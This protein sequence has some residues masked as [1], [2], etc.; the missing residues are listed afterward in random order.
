MRSGSQQFSSRANYNV[1]LRLSQPIHG[2]TYNKKPME[3]ISHFPNVIST[4]CWC[5]NEF[6]Q[7]IMRD[8]RRR[9]TKNQ[10]N[11]NLFLSYIRF[12]LR[13]NFIRQKLVH[14]PFNQFELK[15]SLYSAHRNLNMKYTTCS[16]MCTRLLCPVVPGH[17]KWTGIK[18][19]APIRLL[20]NVK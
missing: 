20:A 1:L 12:K 13:T 2:H 18:S 3:S 5:N 6:I 7:G 4:C 16:R 9:K 10:Q 17:T 14:T 15:T 11:S 19:P 8:G